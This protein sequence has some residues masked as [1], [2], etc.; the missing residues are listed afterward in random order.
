MPTFST[1]QKAVNDSYLYVENQ[2]LASGSALVLDVIANDSGSKTL[3]S[4]DDGTGPSPPQTF[5][6]PTP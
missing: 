1:K 4:I 2:L 5:L 6:W 3:Y